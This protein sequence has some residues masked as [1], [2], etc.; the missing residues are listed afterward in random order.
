MG[1][2]LI[3]CILVAMKKWIVFLLL[4]WPYLSG[5]QN[6]LKNVTLLSR[7]SITKRSQF[8]LAAN[9]RFHSG[10]SAIYG[11]DDFNDSTWKLVTATIFRDTLPHVL[12]RAN[13][14][15]EWYR[16]HLLVDSD[17][18]GRPLALSMVFNGAAEIFVDGKKVAHFGAIR[19]ADSSEYVAP[20]GFPHAIVFTTPG[21]HVVA[22]RFLNY[23]PDTYIRNNHFSGFVVSIGDANR[24]FVNQYGTLL[25]NMPVFLFLLTIFF[26]LF[27]IHLLL[28]LY[29]RTNRSN[30]YFSIFCLSLSSMFVL[31]YLSVVSDDPHTRIVFSSYAWPV[32]LGVSCFS[33]SGINNELFGGKRLRF[34]TIAII[35]ILAVVLNFLDSDTGEI[36]FAGLALLVMVEAIILTIAAIAKKRR[37]ARIVGIGILFFTVFM[38]FTVSYTLLNHGLEFQSGS[39]YGVIFAIIA[40]C[41]VLSIPFSMSVYLSWSFAAINKDLTR[42]LQQVQLLS[43]KNLLQEQEKKRMLETQNEKLEEE[44]AVRTAEV[45][46]QKD[47]IEKQHKELK[48]EKKKSDDLLLN[49]LPGE[50][51]EEL[52]ETGHSQA[53]YFNNVTVLFTDF[54]DFTKAGERMTPQELVD[55]LH[56]CFKTFD[57]IISKYHIEKIKTIGDAYLAVCGLPLP[58][59]EHAV[60]VIRAAVEITQFMAERKTRLKEKVFEVRVGVHSGSVV[61]G[62]V[63]VKKFAYDIWGDTVN[64]AARMEQSSEAGKINISQ[65]TYDLI[66]DQFE[67]TY[68]GEIDAKNKGALRM[69]YVVKQ[70]A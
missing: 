12:P 63:G 51:A 60:N 15:V 29:Y 52:K 33:F 40:S 41:A 43:D 8:R 66:K 42:Q 50:I 61:A 47:E 17:I 26:A 56:T 31:L 68:R 36:V 4:L 1:Q 28:F 11:S 9:W 53:R 59:A 49:I 21:L 38:L 14:V 3:V 62:I 54:V 69:Y 55:E 34:T 22:V 6:S 10:D 57:E 39:I 30:L 32:V 70:T 35:S 27:F 37:G 64:T 23:D 44:V 13:P 5:A 25:N 24:L 67:C 20:N 7:D 58:V 48:V 19:G 46:S 2:H 45:V 16:L 18:V 65:T